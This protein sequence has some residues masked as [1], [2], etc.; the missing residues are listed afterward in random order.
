[1][2]LKSDFIKVL[3]HE[4][5]T[6]VPY[7]VKFT[8]E[9][10]A[11]YKEYL[12]KPFDPVLDTGSYV[13]A[14]HTNNGW[15]ELKPGFYEDYFGAVWNKTIDKTLGVVDDPLLKEPTFGSYRFPD[16][17]KLPVYKFI[18]DNNKK[19]PGHFHM[20]SILSLIHI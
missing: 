9:S 10:L 1:M 3:K 12:N 20:V 14:S 13:V 17:D 2:S 6:P 18:E 8:V 11:R 19:Y 4:N 7:S 16:P 15:K 5:V